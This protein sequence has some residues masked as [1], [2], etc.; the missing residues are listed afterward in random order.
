MN[1]KYFR[2]S[3]YPSV[4]RGF[5]LG[6]CLGRNQK[7]SGLGIRYINQTGNGMGKMWSKFVNWIAPYISRV[8]DYAMPL[9]KSGSKVVGKEVISAASDIANAVLDGKNLKE[10]TNDRISTG[11]DNLIGKP[12]MTGQ[13]I[14][15]RKRR[16]F[17]SFNKT[18][19]KPRT[20]DIFDN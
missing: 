4:Q 11:L 14:N 19:K 1:N 7:G 8:K 20:L 10:T 9:I 6:G 18:T 16:I 15:T 12:E 2:G 5:G 3:A 17:G 13:G